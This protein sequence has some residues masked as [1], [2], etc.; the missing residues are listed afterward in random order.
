M[1]PGQMSPMA[2]LAHEF[3]TVELGLTLLSPAEPTL[4][5]IREDVV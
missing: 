1:M 2:G 5:A 4:M 3:G